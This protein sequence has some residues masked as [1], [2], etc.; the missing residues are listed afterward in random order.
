MADKNFK[1]KNGLTVGGAE[2]VN[3]S[4]VLTQSLITAV[5][6]G[7]TA[8][9]QSVGNSSTALATT[10]YV[11]GEI[12]ALI[13]S[14]PG[15]L[16]TLDELAAAINDDAQFNTTL[17]DAVA[18][19]APLASPTFTGNVSFPN[20][21]I[22]TAHIGDDQVTADKLANSINTDI[23][24][25]VAALPLAGGTMT[26]NIVMADDTSIGISDSAERIEFDGAG[27]ISFL[28]ANVGIG[29]TGPLDALHISSAVSSDYRGNLL[30]DDSTTGFAAG[31]GGQITFGAEYRTNGDHTEWAAIQ[32]A[33][34]NSTDGN[35]SGTLEFKTRAHGGA[36]QAKMILDEDGKVQIGG[37]TTNGLLAIKGT[38]AYFD[39][40]CATNNNSGMRLYENGTFKWQLYNDGDAGD[41]FK[42]DTSSATAMVVTQSGD[43]LIGSGGSGPLTKAQIHTA[44]ATISSGNAIK[45]STMK[46]LTISNSSNDET[47]VGV[48][49]GTNEAHWSG[50]SGQRNDDGTWDTDLRFYTHEAAAADLTY[51]RE[52]M[53]ITGDGNVGI[54]TPSPQGILHIDQGASNDHITILE[55]HS[56]GDVKLIFSQG[57]TAGNWGIGYDDGGGVTADSFS[58]SY[59][60]DG[61]PS[62]SGQNK[63]VLTPAGNVGIGTTSPDTQLHI[64]NPSTSWGQ[65]ATIRLGS[66]TEGTNYADLKYY[67]GAD[68]ATEGFKLNI[69]GTDVLT[70][71]HTGKVG[72]GTTSPV[73]ALTLANST[74]LGW[75]NS[76]SYTHGIFKETNDLKFRRTTGTTANSIASGDISLTILGA[77]GK[78]LIGDTAS[79][80]SDLLQIETPDSGGGHGIQIRRNQANNDAG[81]GHILFG[82]NTAT[83]L[84][85]ISAKTDGDGNSGDSGALLFSTQV[86]NGSLTER[87][88]ID[89][90]GKI[91]AGPYGGNADAIITGSSSPSYTN[92]PGTNLLLK[93]GDGSGGGSSYMSFYTSPPGSSGT[94][95]NTSIERMRIDPSG[96]MLF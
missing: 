74:G 16:N 18:L 80:T 17:T 81:I 86:T 67:R 5:P 57:Q 96:D 91:I 75:I 53:R 7:A 78:V 10:A 90:V 60:A 32:G 72:I 64:Q 93:S 42:I 39:A 19:K 61:Y 95:V 46:G 24:T 73:E 33:K 71:L 43:V 3:S 22:D 28:G 63:M 13:N 66:D 68:A 4:G 20:G 70:A 11:R 50:I 92:H 38:G 40:D 89:S 76:N 23:A 36:L 94:T 85:K 44:G 54:G 35:Y 26:G 15:T 6:S 69:K 12:D 62:L 55:A 14:A 59:K 2:I 31:V 52:R 77:T 58:F 25:G 29:T 41:P 30:L 37:A 83:D 87:M 88:R 27:D 49:F 8:S 79:H 9:T 82:N 48:W 65:Y 21:T 51:S 34:A 56:A 45:S 84:V 47:S 1:V